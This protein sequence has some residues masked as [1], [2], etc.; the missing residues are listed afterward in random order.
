MSTLLKL[1]LSEYDAMIAQGA[2]D[3]LERRHIELIYGELREMSPAGPLHEEIVSLLN[4]WSVENKPK[5]VRI[6]VQSSIGIPELDS[7]P[8]P[9]LA[10][11][12]RVR[13]S[14]KRPGPPDV[15]LA[16]EVSHSR[17]AYDLGE[18]QEL[19]ARAG[20]QEYWVV[21]VHGQ[22]IHV[23]RNPKNEVYQE[24]VIVT[25]GASLFPLV[26]P[27]AALDVSALFGN[28]AE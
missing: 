7:A 1:N 10:W 8:E 22:Q 13:Y 4:E 3:G 16:I 26:E 28:V 9:D 17:L 11:V 5:N 19:Y 23:F 6:R 14:T 15:L 12:R 18:K 27:S 24:S 25:P 21:D 20:V 2:F